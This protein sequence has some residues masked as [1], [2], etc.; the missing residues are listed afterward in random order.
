[1]PGDAKAL[2]SGFDTHAD[3]LNILVNNAGIAELGG[4]VETTPER[5][6]RLFTVNTKAPFFVTQLGLDRL[7]DGGRIV[8][9]STSYTLGHTEPFSSWS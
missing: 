2:W 9:V 6:D 3:G 4:I 8:N 1:M 7:H 5:F